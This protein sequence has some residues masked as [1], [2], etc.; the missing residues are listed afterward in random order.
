M[1][2]S[3]G[4]MFRPYGIGEVRVRLLRR[5]AASSWIPFRASSGP[6]SASSEYN[7]WP[8]WFTT[9]PH[10]WARSRSGQSMWVSRMFT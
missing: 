2:N 4:F 9:S 10:H 7:T 3:G 5:Q 8:S 1:G 6:R